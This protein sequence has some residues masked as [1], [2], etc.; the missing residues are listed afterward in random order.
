[1]TYY[2]VIEGTPTNENW[3]PEYAPHLKAR[4]AGSISHHFLI[5]GV[6]A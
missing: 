1:M 3:I 2:S 5:E 6:D 4:T